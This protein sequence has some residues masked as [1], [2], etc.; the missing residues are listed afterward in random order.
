MKIVDKIES[1]IKTHNDVAYTKLW[2]VSKKIVEDTI[3]H[4]N[5]MLIQHLNLE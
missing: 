2:T 5:L 4:G 3:Q 1:L